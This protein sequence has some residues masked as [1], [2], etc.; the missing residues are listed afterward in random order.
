[1]KKRTADLQRFLEECGSAVPTPEKARRELERSLASGEASRAD[2]D[3]AFACI[4]AKATDRATV[5]QCLQRALAEEG[6]SVEE[7][8]RAWRCSREAIEGALGSSLPIDE[9]S[10][11]QVAFTVASLSQAEYAPVVETLSVALSN[12]VAGVR[13]P[14][15]ER[16][17][18]LAARRKDGPHEA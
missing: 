18:L 15:V 17:E 2:L 7:L 14:S 11:A 12:V 8:A 5:G 10:L 4:W 3:R 9:F 13:S 1:M 6:A 16:A